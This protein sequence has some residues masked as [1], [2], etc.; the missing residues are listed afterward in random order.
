[1]ATVCG[2]ATPAWGTHDLPTLTLTRAQIAERIAQGD[3]LVLHRRLVY[4]LNYWVD[5]HPGGDLAILHFVGRDAKDEIEVYHSETTIRMLMRRFAIAQLAEED[6][7]DIQNGRVFRPLMPPIQLGY[8]DGK[9]DHPDA[10]LDVWKR[11][12]SVHSTL[13]AR[14]QSFPIPT[15]MLEP[16]PSNVSLLDE[17]RISHAFE[18][19]HQRIKDAGLYTLNPWNY[20]REA[21]RYAMVAICS[22]VL[23]HAAPHLQ[24]WWSTTA[25]LGSALALGVLWQQLT[26]V[27]HDAGHCGI[28]HSWP[29][30]HFIGVV[31]AA[32]IGGLSLVWWC[33]NHD[34]H[35]LVTNHPEHDPDI[36]HMPIFAVTP[37]FVQEP[38]A[39]RAK[40]HSQAPR[41]LWSSYYR[42]VMY[43][44]AAAQL[45]LRFQHRLY[46][47][48]MSLARF[49][50]Y[51]LSYSFL[52]LKAKWD[53]WFYFEVVGLVSFW[54]WYGGIVL[55]NLPNWRIALGYM[56]LSHMAASP[57]HVQ[58]VLSHFAQDTS[59][60]GPQ[61]C[62]PSRQI[63]TTM[64]VQCGK[65]IE[66]IHGGLHM[67]VTHHLFP[68]LPRH[69][70][71]AA[72]DLFTRPFCEEMG[73][74]YEEMSFGPGNGKVLR[75]LKDIADQVSFLF[76][77][78]DAQA[79][80]ELHG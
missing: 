71:R 62:F 56:L 14:V 64:D 30:D 23:Y 11:S 20:A 60:L 1:M 48:I 55:A 38:S 7:T 15:A 47:I 52:F 70:L 63:R 8:R 75:R 3:V 49:N 65:E 29:V 67:Q 35:H 27:A 73:L 58:I 9:L 18:V 26:F 17:A 40:Q 59:D 45:L 6:A 32:Y 24:G 43:F 37:R 51:F 4:R 66:F 2:T 36:Q 21:V 16:P 76:C 12:K 10:Q 57:V 54:A 39:P 50:L 19:M 72:R 78:A 34:V 5:K 41:G 68:R 42:R 44:D 31:V 74:L 25:Y 22:Y 80:G 79:R 33:D 61:E 28:T 69:N 53:R 46:Y 77:V 13:D